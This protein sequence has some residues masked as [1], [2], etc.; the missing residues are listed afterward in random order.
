MKKWISFIVDILCAILWTVELI[1]FF[2]TGTISPA[3]VI[4]SLIITILFFIQLA[5]FDFPKK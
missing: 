3:F 2:V 4:G 5:I 1:M